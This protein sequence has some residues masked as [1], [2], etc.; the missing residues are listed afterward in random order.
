MKAIRRFLA[1]LGN[2][3]RRHTVPVF[4][5]AICM[6]LGYIGATTHAVEHFHDAQPE[7]ICHLCIAG[8]QY[9]PIVRKT[10][11][12]VVHTTA[13]QPARAPELAPAARR[14]PI[15]HGVR[16]PPLTA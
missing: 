10:S 7:T 16:A 9:S 4:V 5:L 11:A 8:D 6:L 14:L 15:L 1:R 2:G 12:A 13:E 3:E